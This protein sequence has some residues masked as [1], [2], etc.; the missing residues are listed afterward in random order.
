M[1]K[2]QIN[3]IDLH[4]I[5]HQKAVDLVSQTLYRNQLQGSFTLIIITGNS[6]YLQ[7]IIFEEILENSQYKYYIPTWNLGQIIVDYVE[8]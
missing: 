2:K 7:K 3:E 6:S 5:R 1:K 8:L 4:G